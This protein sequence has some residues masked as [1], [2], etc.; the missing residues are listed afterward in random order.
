MRKAVLRPFILHSSR[1]F[2]TLLL[3]A[4]TLG[5][6]NSYAGTPL[7]G[8]TSFNSLYSGSFVDLTGIHPAGSSGLS[9]LNVA[10]YDFTV[11]SNNTASDAGIGIEP[12]T[13]E[14]ALVYGYSQGGAT[15]ITA[16]EIKS[17]GLPVFDLNSIDIT[18][19]GSPTLG[20]TTVTLTGYRN[21]VAVSGATMLLTLF[22]ASSGEVLRNY[23]VSANSAFQGIDKI[24]ITTTGSMIVTAIGVD[25]INATN[26]TATALPLVMTS[27]TGKQNGNQVQLDWHT[28]DESGMKVFKIQRSADGKTFSTMGSMPA[29]KAGAHR[30]MDQAINGKIYY[31]IETV[32]EDNSTIYSKIISVQVDK[33]IQISIAPNPV[34]NQATVYN[35]PQGAIH[36]RLVDAAGRCV[37]QGNKVVNVAGQLSVDLG[38]QSSGMYQLLI[39][40][41]AIA[42]QAL[43]L[44][45]P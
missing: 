17:N 8:T 28:T 44:V 9:A 10:G 1:Y 2:K 42:P 22:T 33:G 30:F 18:I 6:I 16:L 32:G 39:S 24:R 45:K 38:A 36:Y 27:F 37:L 14:T 26:F 5:T 43:K 7:S 23:D 4:I 13:G 34:Q 25:N 19:D 15:T 41:E 11:F 40:G 35:L 12:F 29:G 3:T 31:R 21:N 20:S